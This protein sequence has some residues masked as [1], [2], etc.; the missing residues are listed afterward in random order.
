MIKILTILGTR[1]EII[2]LSQ[3]MKLFDKIF[4]HKILH[5]GQ[6]YDVNL[7]DNFFKDLDLRNP[8][9]SFECSTGIYS[10]TL[11]NILIKSDEIMEL[12]SP[13]AVLILGDTDSALSSIVAKRRGIPIFHIEAG[14]RSFDDRVPEET[15]RKIVDA[16]ANFNICYS[17]IA[18]ENLLSENQHPDKITVLGSPMHEVLDANMQKIKDSNILKILDVDK[19]EYL[20]VSAHRAETVDIPHNLGDLVYSLNK[21]SEEFKIVMSLHPRTS[22]NLNNFDFELNK[23]ILVINPLNFTNYCSLQMN[24]KMVLSDSG[25]ITEESSILKF[26]AVNLRKSHERQEAN[27]EMHLIKSSL[28][29]PT[30]ISK[31]RF[32]EK[33]D[34]GNFKIVKDYEHKNFSHKV[35]NFIMSNLNEL[36]S[37][38]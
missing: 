13:D 16:I 34:L 35:A 31:I 32:L 36:H 22:K 26:K 30:L 27:E 28:D 4:D 20:L 23:N 14:N 38:F 11:G 18:R 15:N 19:N 9:F 8:D 5:T 25:T 3:T 10:S 17:K 1:P 24:S 33:V 29:Y 7:K 21:L 6:N 12:F 37:K 2:R